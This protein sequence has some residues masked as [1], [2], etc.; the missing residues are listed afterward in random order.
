MNPSPTRADTYDS[1]WKDVLE[2]YL[3]DFFRLFFPDMHGGIDW[4]RP[5]LS[6]D[7]E[8]RKIARHGEVGDR[9]ADKLFQVWTR[10]GDPLEIM[11]NIEVQGSPEA[12][13]AERLYVYNYRA[14][15]RFHRPV[16]SI[17][18]LCDDTSSFH[19]TSFFSCDL[20]GCRAGIEFP[21]VKLREYNGRWSELEKSDNPFATVVMAH[22]K[23]RATRGRPD[24]RYRWKRSLV[25]RLYHKGYRK[26]DVVELFRFID[27][28]MAL[29]PD[30]EHKLDQDIE[31][32][33]TER[34]MKYVT[35]IERR[36]MA[37][38]MEQGIEKGM[39]QG[40]EQ[41]QVELL[42]SL[43][44]QAFGELSPELDKRLSTASRDQIEMWAGRIRDARS[45]AD[46][47]GAD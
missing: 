35:G 19:P 11:A 7:K 3:E 29:P 10:L 28:V 15:D 38:G 24:S 16:L 31:T 42:K 25:R 43:L 41:G 46:V 37:R 39:E 17:A 14:F 1:P 32:F 8:L 21:T 23:T 22:L 26:K 33:E 44:V 27:W 4:Q 2:I 36:A 12:S 45:L 5:P 13:F 34:G 18:V 6:L 9:Y 20:W 30:L 40:I 47:F